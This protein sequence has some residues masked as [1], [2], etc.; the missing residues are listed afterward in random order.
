MGLGRDH[1]YSGRSWAAQD[2]LKELDKVEVPQVIHL[3]GGLQA[4]FGEAPGQSKSRCI[5][6]KHVKRSEK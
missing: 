6:H 3:E 2:I 5:A 1:N 4:I